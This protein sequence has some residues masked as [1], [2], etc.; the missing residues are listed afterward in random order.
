MLPHLRY[1][2]GHAMVEEMSLSPSTRVASLRQ[3]PDLA[4]GQVHVW[5][6][7]QE[8]AR[9]ADF[10]SLLSN[11]EMERASRL[12]TAA[13]F[14][15]FAANHGMLRILLGSYLGMDPRRLQF[16]ANPYGKPS[17]REMG[18]HLRFN[19]THS[20]DLTLIAVCLQ[21]EVGIDVETVRPVEEWEE[22]AKSHF[23]DDEYRCLLAEPM[24]PADLQ[25]DAFFRCWTRKEAV[26]KA[27]GMGLSMPLSSFTVSTTQEAA[28]LH[29]SWNETAASQWTLEH[30]EPAPGFVGA[31]AM[32]GTEW[33]IQQFD[34][35]ESLWSL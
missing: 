14:H 20:D 16:A 1:G 6:I 13:L 24:Q 27:I 11:E 22:I 21:S 8:E 5:K 25:R 23:S 17:L 4:A 15:R 29:C 7:W 30:L 18:L 32:E 19:M 34:C 26:I 28:L 33:S 35:P 9:F 2:S 10:T 3:L 12:R 31:L